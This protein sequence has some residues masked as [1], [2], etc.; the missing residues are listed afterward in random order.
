[1]QGCN[2]RYELAVLTTLK[3]IVNFDKL[4][5]AFRTI[6]VRKSWSL[7]MDR[8]GGQWPYAS[9]CKRA[10]Y[11]SKNGV[12]SDHLPSLRTEPYQTSGVRQRCPKSEFLGGKQVGLSLHLNFFYLF[13]IHQIQI[14]YWGLLLLLLGIKFSF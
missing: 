12:G 2:V 8:T 1:M 3:Q 6:F 11:V 14:S 5:L 9:S 4:T 10:G 13:N 7:H